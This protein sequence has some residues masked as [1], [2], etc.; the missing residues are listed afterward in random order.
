M[1]DLRGRLL[2]ALPE[3]H[4]DAKSGLLA[5]K[6]NDDVWDYFD[7]ID[8]P[9]IPIIFAECERRGFGA[10]MDFTHWFAKDVWYSASIYVNPGLVEYE[11][12][13]G[14]L[15]EALAEAFCTAVETV[16][17]YNS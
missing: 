17:K 7:A 1:S 10:V 15:S 16:A 12:R 6:A 2:R 9:I 11:A 3:A 4:I 5:V 14:T 13:A 8:W